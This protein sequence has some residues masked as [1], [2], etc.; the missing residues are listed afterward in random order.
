MALHQMRRP[1][2]RSGI[3]LGFRL[4]RLLVRAG[5]RLKQFS[6]WDEPSNQPATL[7][8]VDVR[9]VVIFQKNNAVAPLI[10]ATASWF[11][12][13]IK[14]TEKPCR[15]ALNVLSVISLFLQPSEFCRAARNTTI[16]LKFRFDIH[17]FFS[18]AVTQCVRYSARRLTVGV[19]G[20]GDDPPNGMP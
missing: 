4:K 17:P 5:F 1:V 18:V 16:I 20:G 13:S 9:P 2:H 12:Y 14:L 15:S 19:R 7:N 3:G 8:G 10:G 6:V 11:G